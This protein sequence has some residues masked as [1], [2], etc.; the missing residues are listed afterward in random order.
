MLKK[1]F[2][3]CFSSGNGGMEH[4]AIKMCRRISTYAEVTLVGM[5]GSFVEKKA[6]EDFESGFVYQFVS[7]DVNRFFARTFFDP[8]IVALVR[9]EVIKKQP[10]LMVFFGTS[11]IKSIGLALFRLKSKLVLRIGTSISK[12][13]KNIFQK[14]FYQ[15][16]DGFIAIS[17]HIS[18]NLKQMISVSNIRPIQICYPVFECKFH[19]IDS[20]RKIKKNTIDIIYHSRIVRGKGQ[21]D[22]VKAVK[23]V[24]K[25]GVPLKLTLMGS[26]EDD[27]YLSEINSFIKE[28]EL[29]KNVIIEDSKPD[30]SKVLSD[31]DI[32]LGPTYGEGF[33][34]SF[35]EALLAGLI[36]I[37]YD[38]TVFPAFKKMGFDF[39]TCKTGDIDA[40][41][42]ALFD[43]T[44]LKIN[45]TLR[46]ANN[47]K[48]ACTMFSKKAER[49]A[50][51]N[52]YKKLL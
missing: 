13:K 40:L 21:I 47:Q 24:L 39:L 22:A 7:T 20:G 18:T 44:T 6:L 9:K 1:I 48:L 2:I 25:M 52:L 49:F 4:D 26:P 30:V 29:Y 17:E 43:A 34:N 41:S 11:E 16:A 23:N 31:S 45:Q 38:N 14:I 8:R 36:C 50:L 3:L 10:E 42:E 15:R 46:T 28:N 51:E 33:S 27:V 37:S 32:Y 35:V 5:S 12:P 19:N